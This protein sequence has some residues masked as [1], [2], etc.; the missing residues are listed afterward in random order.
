M[1]IPDLALWALTIF[2]V[3]LLVLVAS[4]AVLALLWQFDGLDEEEGKKR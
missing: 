4:F 3:V 1:T 2:S